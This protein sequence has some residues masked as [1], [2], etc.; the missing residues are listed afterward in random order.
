MQPPNFT[1]FKNLSNIVPTSVENGD[2]L[3]ALLVA[4]DILRVQAEFKKYKNTKIIVFTKFKGKPNKDHFEVISKAIN[5]EKTSI[6]F[7]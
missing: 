3:A 1:S 7:V 6:I 5:E 4:F 2:W